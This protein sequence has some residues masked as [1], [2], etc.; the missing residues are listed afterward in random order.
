MLATALGTA[1]AGAVFTAGT[2]YEGG[3]DATILHGYAGRRGD[4][5]VAGDGSGGKPQ[6]GSR[7]T[8]QRSISDSGQ[9]AKGD[10]I[11][12]R[13]LNGTVWLQGHVRD[14]EHLNKAVALVFATEGVT[15]NEVIRDELTLDGSESKS[16]AAKTIVASAAAIRFAARPRQRQTT[17][18][19]LRPCLRRST[20]CI[21]RRPWR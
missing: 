4:W 20:L 12:V 9:L 8:Y 7:T 17:R 11:A 1:T 3:Y 13:Y 15:M 10:R 5:P 19:T 18:I 6:P 2:R 21:V 16:A 14:Q